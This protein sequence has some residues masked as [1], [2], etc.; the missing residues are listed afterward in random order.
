MVN[1]DQGTSKSE[2]CLDSMAFSVVNGG[3]S[4]GFKM[5]NDDFN[6]AARGWGL[7]MG[8]GLSPHEWLSWLI[9]PNWCTGPTG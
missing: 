6:T 7:P 5:A 3:H 9:K 1:D 2:Y 8:P 4:D